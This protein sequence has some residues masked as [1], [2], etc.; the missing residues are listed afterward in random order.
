[1]LVPSPPH[2]DARAPRR[3]SLPAGSAL[4]ACG[5]DGVG[6]GGDDAGHG[7]GAAIRPAEQASAAGPMP[8]SKSMG[9]WPVM[10]RGSAGPASSRVLLRPEAAA[11]FQGR[12]PRSRPGPGSGA[13][14]LGLGPAESDRRPGFKAGSASD[15]SEYD[16]LGLR[17]KG[18]SDYDAGDSDYVS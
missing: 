10:A 6:R 5:G 11:C 15:G 17:R 2:H 9:V 1:M 4:P 14:R 12:L 13:G 18:D 16:G 8:R 3:L 7:G